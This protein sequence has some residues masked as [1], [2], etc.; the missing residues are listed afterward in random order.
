MLLGS[1]DTPICGTAKLMCTI[2]SSQKMVKKRFLENLK[3]TGAGCNCLPS[4]TTIS[5]D[6]ETSQANYDYKKLFL[7]LHDEPSIHIDVVR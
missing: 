6:I 7:A 4:C 3:D 2:E 1:K 5:Y